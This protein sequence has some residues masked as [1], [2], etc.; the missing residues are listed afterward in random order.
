MG[1][2]FTDCFE[3]NGK[4]WQYISNN[5]NNGS[6]FDGEPIASKSVVDLIGVAGVEKIDAILK[7]MKRAKEILY[8]AESLK[9]GFGP[10]QYFSILNEYQKPEN[11]PI[12]FNNCPLIICNAGINN[13]H[14]SSDD[15]S[16]K[17]LKKEHFEMTHP[18]IIDE[19]IITFS[20]YVVHLIDDIYP[21]EDF[22]P[23]W[24][25]IKMGD[26]E[27]LSEI[28]GTEFLSDLF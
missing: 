4:R 14:F 18:K 26:E 16:L 20:D 19:N 13:E 22:R 28:K 9:V 25:R 21:V 17:W 15:P 3:A 5:R 6:L 12:I 10:F 8:G 27:I 23:E 1:A 2:E 11:L 24:D 7:G